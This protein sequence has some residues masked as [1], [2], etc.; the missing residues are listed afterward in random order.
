[1]GLI[2][3]NIEKYS[4]KQLVMIPLAILAV[5]LL[6]LILN[7]ATTGMPVTP[8][9]DFSGGTAVTI[10]TTDTREQISLYFADYPL[11]DVSDMNNGKF[12]KFGL[13]DDAKYKSLTSLISQ[14]YPDAR[15]DQ[16][17]E[18][19][20]KS[21][22]SQAVLALIFSFI[23]MSIVVFLSFRTFVPSGAVVLSAFADIVMT[24]ATMNLLGIQLSL[25]TLAALLMLI[26]YSVDSDILLSWF[27]AVQIIYEISAVLLIGLL[28]DVMN[29]WLTNVGILKWYVLKG[30]GK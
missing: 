30:G 5:A 29:T 24:A 13:M 17:G 27:G 3:Y 4:P 1:M 22:Q 11:S 26:G 25:G 16:I 15:I 28:F 12:L 8:G 23:G 21:L 7:I 9:I 18:T 10:I 2:N 6:L 14:R 20:G 19:F